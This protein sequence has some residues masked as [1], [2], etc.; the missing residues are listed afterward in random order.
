[1][2]V[3]VVDSMAVVAALEP[4]PVEVEV[5]LLAVEAAHQAFWLPSH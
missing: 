3:L 4:E 2:Q 1:M 5:A